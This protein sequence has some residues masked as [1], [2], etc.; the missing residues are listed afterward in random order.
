MQI[1]DFTP[2]RVARAPF[3]DERVVH[4]GVTLRRL[5][6]GQTRALGGEVESCDDSCCEAKQV[7][8]GASKGASRS[9]CGPRSEMVPRGIS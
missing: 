6:F 3:Q 4:V 8:K 5:C 2:T 1:V 9:L 7:V